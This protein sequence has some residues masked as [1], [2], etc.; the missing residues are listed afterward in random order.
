MVIINF[1]VDLGDK[2]E[3]YRSYFF[4]PLYN[5]FFPTVNTSLPKLSQYADN[6]RKTDA[7]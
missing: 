2:C 1:N 7:E 4:L 3:R 5:Y 6:E